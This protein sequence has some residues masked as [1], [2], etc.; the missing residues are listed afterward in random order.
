MA[1]QNSL[2]RMRYACVTL[3]T[4]RQSHV[5][6][7]SFT[8]MV[9]KLPGLKPI[10][11]EN[12][13]SNS[14]RVPHLASMRQM[15]CLIFDSNPELSMAGR[16]SVATISFRLL[17]GLLIMGHGR[18]HILWFGVTRIRQPTA[19]KVILHKVARSAKA[20]AAGKTIGLLNRK[21][22]IRKLKM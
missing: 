15:P 10:E 13:R 3:F 6:R 8:P 2:K 5:V 21:G 16:R 9:M 18:R 14:A 17:Y 11:A 22:L 19:W 4:T 7:F 20:D 1:A 12:A